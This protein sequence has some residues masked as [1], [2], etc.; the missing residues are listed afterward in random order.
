MHLASPLI[1]AA[2]VTVQYRVISVVLYCAISDEA[3]PA[4]SNSKLSSPSVPESPVI[5]LDVPPTSHLHD[6]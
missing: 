4:T 1:S 3:S 2:E 6:T 5:I